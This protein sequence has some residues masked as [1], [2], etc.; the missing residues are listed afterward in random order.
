MILY[1]LIN[2]VQRYRQAGTELQ[3]T[4]NDDCV[5]GLQALQHLCLGF[6][7]YAGLYFYR[8]CLSR[9]VE[10]YLVFTHF[11]YDG[12]RGD[13]KCV[14]DFVFAQADVRIAAR[15]DC[16]IGV[17][18]EGTQGQCMGTRV[19]TGLAGIYFGMECLEFAFQ[20]EVDPCTDFHVVCITLGN[21]KFDFQRRDFGQ[22]GDD[23]R[24]WG[25]RTDADLP[26]ADDSIKR[27]AQFGL[28]DVCLDEVDV[29][30]RF[31]LGNLQ[32]LPLILISSFSSCGFMILAFTFNILLVLRLLLMDLSAAASS[33]FSL[34]SW[35]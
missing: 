9:F 32:Q 15:H 20:S 8:M 4:G 31:Q 24:R 18:I 1:H 16:A 35:E 10:E 28:R 22:F 26:Q 13:G 2:V 19:H 17:R 34:G 29:G 25:I 5:S 11:R 30:R 21:G 23:G 14:R 27:S 6:R 3:R 12:F 7:A 33:L